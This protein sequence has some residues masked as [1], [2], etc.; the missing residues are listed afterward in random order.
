MYKSVHGRYNKKTA[1]ENKEKWSKRKAIVYIIECRSTRPP[2]EFFYK[3]G[4]TTTSV[5]ERFSLGMPYKWRCMQ[6]TT[7]SLYD[8]IMLEEELQNKAAKWK[9]LPAIKFSGWTETFTE[10][11]YN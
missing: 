1:E 11:V 6:T 4:I 8:A 2:E 5:P 10:V 7:C 9:Y 3:I